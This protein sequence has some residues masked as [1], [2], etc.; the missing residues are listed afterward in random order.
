MVRILR[1]P[2]LV[3]R[4]GWGVPRRW[5]LVCWGWSRWRTPGSWAGSGSP[6]T[7]WTPSWWRRGRRGTRSSGWSWSLEQDW[8]EISV[9]LE[10]ELS[11]AYF[12]LLAAFMIR[13]SSLF[14]SVPIWKE[15]EKFAHFTVWLPLYLGQ[16]GNAEDSIRW[17]A[18]NIGGNIIKA[19][20]PS[21]LVARLW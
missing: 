16:D 4:G 19:R 3:V 2:A 15:K 7:E 20:R 6:R 10:S 14:G 13:S 12:S 1:T 8:A 11:P 5:W 21:D 17:P 18:D 9:W